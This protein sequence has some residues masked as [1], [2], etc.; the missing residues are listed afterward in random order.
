MSCLL[1]V[2]TEASETYSFSLL[3]FATDGIHTYHAMDATYLIR[4]L[5]RTFGTPTKAEV[6][7]RCTSVQ[8]LIEHLGV[9]PR[10][11]NRLQV[12]LKSRC[13]I[14]GSRDLHTQRHH[15]LLQKCYIPYLLMRDFLISA[16]H[17]TNPLKKPNGC[18]AHS[19][20]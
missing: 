11:T 15:W 17:R 4:S 16:S 20:R 7:V 6:I 18:P 10:T 2:R 13:D 19:A 3:T 14:R 1:V 5:C 9:I 8:R 12:A